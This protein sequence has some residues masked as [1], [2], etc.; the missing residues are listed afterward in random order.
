MS[1][2]EKIFDPVKIGSRPAFVASFKG[3]AEGDQ[4]TVLDIVAAVHLKPEGATVELTGN[5]VIDGAIKSYVKCD[6][7]G[8]VDISLTVTCDTSLEDVSIVRIPFSELTS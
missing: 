4:A 5:Y 7:A 1:T 2:P 6:L 3:W 8:D